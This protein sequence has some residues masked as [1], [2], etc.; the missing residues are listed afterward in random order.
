MGIHLRIQWV[1]V[2]PQEAGQFFNSGIPPTRQTI[3]PQQGTVLWEVVQDMLNG[4]MNNDL[5]H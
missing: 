4:K 1:D 2:F 3:S 5:V